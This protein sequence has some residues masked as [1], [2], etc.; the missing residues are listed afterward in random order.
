LFTAKGSDATAA[1]KSSVPGQL[2]A[3]ESVLSLESAVGG[4]RNSVV[5]RST[6]DS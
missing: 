5:G 1:R 3:C 4:S 2:A 6:L